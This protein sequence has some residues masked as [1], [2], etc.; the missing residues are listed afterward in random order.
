MSHEVTPDGTV[1]ARENAEAALKGL[2]SAAASDPVLRDRLKAAPLDTLRDAGLR[3][4]DGVTVSV[5]EVP[6][7]ELAAAAARS[8]DRHVV[9]PLPLPNA[10]LSDQD[11]DAVSGGGPLLG[12]LATVGM[13]FA[14]LFE[15]V[16]NLG[17]PERMGAR[18]ART[19]Q[20]VAELWGRPGV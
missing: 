3:V 19:G 17:N 11:L 15:V 12:V 2:L 13:P 8:T 7:A 1:L 10:P 16:A 14:S 20:S 5:E 9:L 6:L 18:L 4:A